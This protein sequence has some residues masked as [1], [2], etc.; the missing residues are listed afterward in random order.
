M[1]NR[2]AWIKGGKKGT[3]GFLVLKKAGD[4]SNCFCNSRQ[5]L[6]QKLLQGTGLMG[7][8]NTESNTI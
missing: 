1:I 3:T 2:V 6:L 8:G 7:E 5:G 4:G